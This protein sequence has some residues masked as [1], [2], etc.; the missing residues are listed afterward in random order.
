MRKR[1]TFGLLPAAA[2]TIALSFPGCRTPPD[3]GLR[4]GP[5]P[6]FEEEELYAGVGLA[7]SLGDPAKAVAALEE[8]EKKDPHSVETKRL[9]SQVLLM[10]GRV[11]EARR[12][13]EKDLG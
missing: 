13:L 6:Q 10:A 11:D 5:P 4:E 2:L 8:A 1:Y 7:L 3:G 9:L 12:S